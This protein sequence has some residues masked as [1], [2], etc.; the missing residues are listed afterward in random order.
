MQTYWCRRLSRCLLGMGLLILTLHSP[1][2]AEDKEVQE[3][4]ARLDKLEK[5]NE[6]LLRAL[7]ELR[8]GP[9][10]GQPSPKPVGEA[11]PEAVRKIVEQ[12]LKDEAEQRKQQE[13][14]RKAE[15]EANGSEVGK[16]LD[17]KVKWNYGL[18]A[19][20]NDKAFRIHV[21]GRLQADLALM[22]ANDRVQFGP[23]G[24]G[25][26]DDAVNFRRARF[27]IDGTMYEVIDFWC[28]YDF[29]N[30][31]NVGPNRDPAA[32]ENTPV[33]TD[34]WVQLA[35][36]P[37]V[38][39]FRAGNQKPF[40]SFEHLISSRFLDFLERSLPFDTFVGGLNNG[41]Q[42]GLQLF[43]WT[44]NERATWAIGLFKY[45]QSVFGWNV[46]DGEYEVVGRLTYLPFFE[47]DGRYLVHVGLGTSHRAL[48]DGRQRLRTRTSI[49]NGPFVLH[50]PLLDTTVLGDTQTLLVPELAIVYGPLTVAAEFYGSFL[51]NAALPLQPRVLLGTLYSQGG[52]VQALYFL[53]GE[54][55]SYERRLPR[56]ARVVPHEN[57]FWVRGCG[58]HLFGRGAWQVGARYSWVNLNSGGLEGG[59]AQDLTLGLNWF[60]NPNLK[61]QWNYCLAHRDVVGRTSDG[62][63]QGFG[64]RFAWDF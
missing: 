29:E 56:F 4:K 62:F 19:E 44:E 5:Q 57:F 58:G 15:A 14:A 22:Q 8:K 13:E 23:G 53:T 55:R 37:W 35:H 25:R 38:G 16:D 39:N 28:E 43:N 27:T 9:P 50:T 3:L 30:V 34:C 47:E 7:E 12:Y 11:D 42:P 6:Q 32:V 61:V 45:N 49:R 18:Q 20:T 33:P 60:L 36:L 31:F 10:G 17:M 21:G 40:Y 46:G 2:R 54:H 26:V 48:D 24:V 1:V 52:Y 64:M 51:Q 59:I 41:F 63:V